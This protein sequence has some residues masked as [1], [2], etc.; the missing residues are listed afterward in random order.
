M[1]T[2]PKGVL[3]MVALELLCKSSLSGKDLAIEIARISEGA[4]TPSPGSIYPIFSSML[5]EGLISEIPRKGGNTRRYIVTT[6]GRSLLEQMRKKADKEIIRQ[7]KV[8]SIICEIAGLKE[9]SE[10]L[11]YIITE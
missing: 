10:K 2:V 1:I 6:K 9:L 8:I 7:L 4:W 5:N 11:K 3:K